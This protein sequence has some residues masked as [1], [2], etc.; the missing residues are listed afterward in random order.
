MKSQKR[1]CPAVCC[2]AWFGLPLHSSG[3]CSPSPLAVEQGCQTD[4]DRLHLRPLSSQLLFPSGKNPDEYAQQCNEV[5]KWYM[6]HLPPDR[7]PSCHRHNC[8]KT[9]DKCRMQLTVNAKTKNVDWQCVCSMIMFAR[10][11][12]L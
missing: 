2:S 4:F 8:A 1:I 11:Q 5:V 12:Q 7:P 3:F 10:N 6:R 9:F